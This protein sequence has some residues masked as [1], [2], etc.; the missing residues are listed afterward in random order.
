MTRLTCSTGS[1]RFDDVMLYLDPPY[2]GTDLSGYAGTLPDFDALVEV[3]LKQ[4]GSVM[5][6]G[7][8]DTWPALTEAGWHRTLTDPIA[9]SMTYHNDGTRQEAV[10]TNYPLAENL[11]MF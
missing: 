6:S 7:Y 8:P 11:T 1:P 3:L 4:A 10:W 9:G 5:I 2:P